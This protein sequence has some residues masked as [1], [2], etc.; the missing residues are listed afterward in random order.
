MKKTTKKKAVLYARVSSTRQEKEGFSVPAQISFLREYAL[1]LN[2]DIV[3]EFVE[4][5]TAKKAGRKQFNHMLKFLRKHKDVNIILT[6]KTDRL[7]R[8]FKD[9]VTVD[10]LENLELHLVKEGS[11]ISDDSTSTE[12]L[13]HTVKVVMAKW[14][15][16]NLREEV[17]KGYAEKAKQGIYPCSQVPYGYKR[18]DKDTVEFDPLKSKLVKRAFKLYSNNDISLNKLI[19]KLYDEGFIYKAEKPKIPKSNLEKILKN[20]FYTGDFKMN[21]KI[22]RG[23]HPVLID[24]ITFEKVQNAFRKD[25]KPIRLKKKGFAL[26]GL[27]RCSECGCAITAEIKKGK[28]VYYHCTNGKLNCTQN[29]MAVREEVL[30]KTL[31]TA[32]SYIKLNNEEEAWFKDQIKD[33]YKLEQKHHMQELTRLHEELSKAKTRLDKNYI[34]YLDEVISKEKYIEKNNDLMRQIAKYENL[35]QAHNKA[36]ERFKNMALSTLEL[37]KDLHSVYLSKSNPEKANLVK[38]VLSNLTLKDRNLSY[39]YKKPFSFFAKGTSCP[40]KWAAVDSNHRPHPYQGCAL[41]T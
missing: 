9:Y 35:L 19:S 32:I 1:K 5:E 3:E 16:D 27:I 33:C 24:P 15:I 29:K 11:I 21:G 41:T 40:L 18:I 26:S 34:A 25:N 7:Y 39:E 14:Y 2:I 31:D 28:Y 20:V 23:N 10:E 8:N 13:M 12:K 38:I 6:E 30:F 4:A 37:L 22:F 17:K 36:N